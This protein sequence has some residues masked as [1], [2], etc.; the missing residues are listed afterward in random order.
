MPSARRLVSLACL[1]LVGG[2]VPAFAQQGLDTPETARFH[3]GPLSLTPKIAIR[4]VGFDTNVFSSNTAPVQDL[5]ATFAPGIDAW[6][7][8]GRVLLSSRTVTE[9]VYFQDAASERSFNVDEQCRLD[10]ILTRMTPRLSGVFLNTRQRP[11]DEIDERVQQKNVGGGAGV[12][13]GAGSRLRLDFDAGRMRYDY[14]DGEY[15]DPQV[16]LALNRDTATVSL[17]ARY[18]LT[19]LTSAA[20]RIDSIQDR[21]VYSTERDGDSLRVMPGVTF[22]PFALV[23]GN[24][25]VGMRRLRP[26]SPGAPEFSGV[27]AAVELKYVALDMLRVTGLVK[28][29]LD[30][31]L[32]LDEPFFVST[33]VGAE[34]MQLLGLNWDVVGRIRRGTLLYPKGPPGEI[35]RIDTVHEASAGVGRRIGEGYRIGVD[36]YYVRRVSSIEAHTYD[37]LRVGGSFT[38]G[39]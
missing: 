24:A 26:L 6:L 12:T 28:R 32:E 31:S 38:Y 22:Q 27:V 34:A 1:L 18:G 7:K 2:W 33:S 21:F 4:N 10:V 35:Q 23:S 13:V 30:Y 36:V 19:S 16:A 37:G 9:W 15:G 11:N 29:D 17:M 20:V 8:G 3:F 39:Y 14:A 25:F 5:T